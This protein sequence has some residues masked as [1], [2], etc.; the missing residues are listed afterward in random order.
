MKTST[1]IVAAR[2]ARHNVEFGT[3]LVLAITVAGFW[4][5]AELAEAVVQ[6]STHDLDRDVL[7]LMRTQGELDNPIGPPWV[8]EVFRDL[9]AA[10]GIAILTLATLAVATFFL[11]QGKRS[12]AIYLLVAV[13][14]GLLI[15][16]LAKGLFDRPRPDLVPHGSFVHTASFPSGHSIMAAVVYLTLGV[17]VART[18]PH[19][20]LK[21]FVLL[22]ATLTTLSVGVSRV[23]LGVHWPSDVLAGW[24]AGAVWASLC[25]MGARFLARRGNV[26]AEAGRD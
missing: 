25:M 18:L 15:S 16:S 9:T 12:S 17:L 11:L 7:L 22:L 21:V 19:R 8:E 10:G 24:L 13:G 26:E 6:G 14:G 20:R 3:L 2:W 23:Y 5:F 4:G 1:L